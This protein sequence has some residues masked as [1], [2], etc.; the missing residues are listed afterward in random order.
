MDV[1]MERSIHFRH[2]VAAPH[3][4]ANPLPSTMQV[5]EVP[6]YFVA[7]HEAARKAL[8]SHGGSWAVVVGTAVHDG[9]ETDLEGLAER[10]LEAADP[11]EETAH[12]CGAFAAM[13]CA[14]DGAWVYHDAGATHKVFYRTLDQGG[15]CCG[16]DPLL[17]GYWQ[18]LS[19][20]ENVE[21]R[22]F[23]ESHWLRRRNTRQ[24]D[25]TWFEG[26]LQLLPNHSLDLMSAEAD[27]TLP[28]RPRVELC[29]EEVVREV[30]ARMQFVMGQWLANR[31]V[32]VGM[33]A[34]WDSRIVLAAC[35]PGKDRLHT[36]STLI[37][38]LSANHPD[39]AVPERMAR[40]LGF[41]HRVIHPCQTMPEGM[42]DVLDGTFDRWHN[43]WILPRLGWFKTFDPDVLAITGVISE[44]AKNFLEQAPIDTPL[45]AT[46]AVHFAEHP[47]MM[48]YYQKWLDEDAR[49]VSAMGYA[50]RDFMH[51]E[52][53]ACNVAGASIHAF[54]FVVDSVTPFSSHHIL[55]TLLA[56][57]PALRDK[58]NSPLYKALVEYMWPELMQYPVNPMLR[59][60]AIS[61]SKKLGIYGP[62]K[63]LHSRY[64]RR[65]FKG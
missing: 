48:T 24:G 19:P 12:W 63:Y 33:S 65:A 56:S 1:L 8:A 60:R 26:V 7:V 46:R 64:K 13:R 14:A 53:D 9:V 58:H 4:P 44:V 17:L 10:L 62:Y 23:Q 52:Q 21:E 37:P 15:L 35:R 18:P 27:R 16:S 51:W 39:L 31:N 36:Y 38:G 49:H 42:A 20:L 5:L 3:A 6:G 11:L 25:R 57:P 30:A 40:D 34:G 61:W 32:Q 59:D 47:W 45:H 22:A 28:R 2:F 50:P 29:M 41:A 54:N 43:G 55:S